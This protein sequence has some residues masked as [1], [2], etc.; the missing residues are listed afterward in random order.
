MT[1]LLT[2]LFISYCVLS[3]VPYCVL[4]L[5]SLLL[6]AFIPYCVLF[7][8]SL[9]CIVSLFLI[10][11][12]FFIP[13]CLL[14]YSLLCIDFLY[15]TLLIFLFLI[16]P[17]RS[18]LYT[19]ERFFRVLRQQS[20]TPSVHSQK[21]N[22]KI[23]KHRWSKSIKKKIPTSIVKGR[24]SLLELIYSHKT[25]ELQKIL[26]SGVEFRALDPD[27]VVLIKAVELG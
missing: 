26:D 11:Y 9:L 10:V 17:D 16:A 12:S 21:S 13:Y 14:F 2:V 19:M 6:I 3:F 7:L 1:S 24:D 22:G 8:C 4:F 27:G 25:D 5:C 15:S 18:S 20:S 23:Q